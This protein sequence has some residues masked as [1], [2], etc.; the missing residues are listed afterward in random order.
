MFRMTASAR[1]TPKDVFLHLLATILLY[2]STYAIISLLFAC[3]NVLLPDPLSFYLSGHLNTIRLS[4]AMLIVAFPVYVFIMRLIG[5]DIAAS[6]AKNDIAARKWLTY[7]TVFLAALLILID[8]ITLI[9][10]FLNGELGVRFLLKVLVVLIVASA[11]FGFYLW[12]IRTSGADRRKTARMAAWGAS[13]F[14]AL[15]IA[16][17]FAVAGSPW[18]QRSVRFDERRVSD[19]QSIQYQIL[20]YWQQKDTLPPSLA[21]LTDNISGFSAPVDPVTGAPYDYETTGPLSFSLCADFETESMLESPGGRPSSPFGEHWNHDAGRV[22]FDRSIDPELHDVKG[23]AP[24]R[25][26]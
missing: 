26:F 9:Y 20:N 2:L 6:P 21:D 10:S 3:I 4:T 1:S 12:D 7:L 14:V 5:K 22:C 8:V 18:Y 19:L 13:T 25:G 23:L 15:S 11:V 17:S 16:G 24:T